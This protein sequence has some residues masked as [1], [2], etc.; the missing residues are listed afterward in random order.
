MIVNGDDVNAYG[1]FVEHYQKFEVIWN[2]QNGEDVFFQNEMPYDPPSQ[3]AWMS[4]PTTDGYAAF[5]VSPRVTSFQGY[6]MG[7]YSFFNQGVPIFATQAFQFRNRAR[8]GLEPLHALVGLGQRRRGRLPAVAAR[9]DMAG[10]VRLCGGFA[11]QPD[12]AARS[13]WLPASAVEIAETAGFLCELLLFGPDIGD[14]LI[15][16][17][18]PVAMA[19]HAGLKLVAL[20]GEVGENGGQ[21]GE[22]ALG[23]GQRRFS[24]GHP[25]IDAT[26]FFDAR[27][28]LFL[29]FGVFGVEPLQRHFGV[30][31]LLLLAGDIGG[32]LRQPAVEFGDAF[33]GALF[34]AVEQSR[35]HW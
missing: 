21:F 7:S 23:G 22:Q 18:Q 29:Q 17:R 34:L 6:G 19:A 30:R 14:V 3:S 8:F 10:F 2:G 1:L 12:V 4:S 20:G 28:D 35:G 24:F 27:L 9:G 11:T 32:K 16:P 13:P 25:F 26:A 33:L 5:L 31:G 15:E